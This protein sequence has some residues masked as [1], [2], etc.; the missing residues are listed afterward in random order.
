[1]NN[2]LLTKSFL[3][4]IALAPY[5]IVKF[6]VDDDS[7]TPA[8]ADTDALVGVVDDLGADAGDRVDVHLVGVTE[9]EFGGNVTRGVL[10]TSDANGK[11]IAAAPA[12]DTNQS[13]IGRAMVSGADGEIGSVLLAAGQIQGQP[14]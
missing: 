7:V 8:T 3:A 9:V 4:A 12:N 14:A 1:M 13:V 5:R 11:A 6:G 2:P 10:L